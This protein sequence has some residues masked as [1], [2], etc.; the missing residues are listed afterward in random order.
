MISENEVLAILQDHP[1]G[2][3]EHTFLKALGFENLLDPLT[4]FRGHFQLF[5]VL[6][7]LRGRFRQEQSAQ[8]C[9]DPLRIALEPYQPGQEGLTEPDYL[10]AYYADLSHLDNTTNADVVQLLK[11]FWDGYH[12]QDN[13]QS[14]LAVLELTD[15]VDFATIKRQYRRL[16]MRH[17]PDRGGNRQRLQELNAALEVLEKNELRRR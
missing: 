8:L 2:L 14:A 9:I 11:K 10:H 5:H 12:S 3:D 17:H 16:A 15:P 1:D 6:Y 7:A 4:L 13:R